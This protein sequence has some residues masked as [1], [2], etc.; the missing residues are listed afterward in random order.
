MSIAELMVVV[1]VWALLFYRPKSKKAG[2]QL[3]MPANKIKTIL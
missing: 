2:T 3:R 1:A